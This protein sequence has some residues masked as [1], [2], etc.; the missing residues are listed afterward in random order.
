M[1]KKVIL[2]GVLAIFVITAALLFSLAVSTYFFLSKADIK[3]VNL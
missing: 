3:D 2:L 1:A